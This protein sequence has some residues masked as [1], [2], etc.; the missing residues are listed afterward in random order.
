MQAEGQIASKA[1]YTALGV[2]L[3]GHK[4]VLGRW[5]GA[6][7]SAQFWLGVLSE[8][9]QRG[10]EDILI[11]C[12]D[13]RAGFSEAIG[14]VFAGTVVQKCVVHQLRTSTRYVSYK[15]RKAVLAELRPVYTAPSEAAGQA[16]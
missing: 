14:A 8:L 1:A 16:A 3:A 11:A 5:I 13:N 7:E 6:S 2:D 4:E 12:T 15:D 9:R 10:V